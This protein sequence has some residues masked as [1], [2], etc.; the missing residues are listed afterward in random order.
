MMWYKGRLFDKLQWFTP[1]GG[2]NVFPGVLQVEFPLLVPELRVGDSVE[3]RVAQPSEE[4][5]RVVPGGEEV[6]VAAAFLFGQVLAASDHLGAQ[7]S[8]TVSPSR[9][10]CQTLHNQKIRRVS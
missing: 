8:D 10:N 4:F 9:A 6:S 2:S 7:T 5:P 3:V 1:G